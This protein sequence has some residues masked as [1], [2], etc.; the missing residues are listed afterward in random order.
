MWQQV[1]IQPRSDFRSRQSCPGSDS[2]SLVFAPVVRKA[3][4][5]GSPA[6]IAMLLFDPS[7]LALPIIARQIRQVIDCSPTNRECE[8]GLR[9]IRL[10]ISTKLFMKRQ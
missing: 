10:R 3:L 7:M 6:F 8:L 5:C 9:K 1:N 4:S 2:S